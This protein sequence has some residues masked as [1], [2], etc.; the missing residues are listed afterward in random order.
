MNALD[1][2]L[3]VILLLVL[4]RGYIK[5]FIVEICGLVAV[6]LSAW[7]AY[8]FYAQIIEWLR[9]DFK[10]EVQVAFVIG[11]LVSYILI[12]LLARLLTK[13]LDSSGLGGMNKLLGML[14]GAV[15]YVVVLAMLCAFFDSVNNGTKWVR[16]ETLNK[17]FFYRPLCSLSET[18]F[19]YF[20]DMKE[21]VLQ[22]EGYKQ[23]TG[24]E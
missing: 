15:K 23:F 19:P 24:G 7:F 14:T 11:F 12:V 13:L 9:F 5:G 22:S 16:P 18:L 4:I 8:R 10:Y 20:S 3:L 6:F 17:S 21:Y 1:I 2:V